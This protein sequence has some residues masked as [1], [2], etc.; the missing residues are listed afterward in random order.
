MAFS[1]AFIKGVSKHLPKT[2]IS[3]APFHLVA[4]AAK[5]W[6]KCVDPS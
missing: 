5:R 6:M 1:A 2:E 3:F 4:L